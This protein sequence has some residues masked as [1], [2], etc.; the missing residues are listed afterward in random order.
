MF[1][2]YLLKCTITKEYYYGV[3]YAKKAN[4]SEFWKTYFTSSK[5]VKQRI[6]IF[7][8]E[9]FIF[10]I[11]KTFNDASCARK[12]EDTVLRRLK[13]LD[14][15]DFINKSYGIPFE[16]RSTL[17][18]K[19]Q[20]FLIKENKYKFVDVSLANFLI[21]NNQA[22]LKG[23][24]KPIGFGENISK[25]LKGKSKSQTH[26]QKMKD[27]LLGKN[28]GS[29][30]E[31][32]GEQKGNE[33]K[34]S[35]SSSLINYYENNIHDALGKTYEE[36]HGTE[37]ANELRNI[38]SCFLKENNPAKKIKGKTYE[39]LYGMDR[40]EK[41]KKNRSLVGKQNKKIYNVYLKNELLFTG[42]RA[43]AS[44]FISSKFNIPKSNILYNKSLLEKHNIIV[45][46][47]RKPR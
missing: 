44:N 23:K 27:S 46:T 16:G 45:K 5:E 26:V 32:Y 8:K 19:K 42:D 40:A 38:R 17:V 24:P 6:D 35:I 11:R 25:K 47:L 15:T 36:R 12:W 18:G 3:R 9:A 22:I 43:A 10:E 29:Y 28:K 4:P 34:S 31:K 14:R 13:V 37:K 39:D 21:K 30:I 20:I 33:L 7:G 41:L 2:T 1:Y